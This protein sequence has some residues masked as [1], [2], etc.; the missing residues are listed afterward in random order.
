MQAAAREVLQEDLDRMEKRKSEIQSQ[1]DSID[2]GI[3]ISK[4]VKK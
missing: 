1:M 2:A 3:I 4:S